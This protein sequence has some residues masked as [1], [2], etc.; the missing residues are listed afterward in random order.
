MIH[1]VAARQRAEHDGRAWLAWHT[2]ALT[3]YAPRNP[4]RF[5]KLKKL[6]APAAEP[7]RRRQSPAEIEAAL[8]AMLAT[9]PGR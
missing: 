9:G 5:T 2:A 3:A 1:G 8:R 4:R 7:R 6:R